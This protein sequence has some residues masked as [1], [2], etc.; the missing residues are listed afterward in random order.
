MNFPKLKYP[1]L[2]RLLTYLIVLGAGAIPIVA[3]YLIPCP[4]FIRVIVLL[5]S[6][7]GYCIIAYTILL[8]WC[9]W[10]LPWL[11]FPAPALPRP[12]T[13]FPKDEPLTI[14]AAASCATGKAVS[15][16]PFSPSPVLC[17]TSSAIPLPSI[18]AALSVWWQHTK[19]IN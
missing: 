12:N 4:D 1:R 18:P 16:S 5:A 3:V 8:C 19:W 14:S 11:C 9:P 6:A 7:L 17:A 13:F 2:C 10:M 15:P